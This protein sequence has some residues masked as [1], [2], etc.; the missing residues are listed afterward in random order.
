MKTY[1]D[2]KYSMQDTAYLYVGAKYTLGEILGNEDILYKFRKATAENLIKDS[3]KEDTLET[4]LYYLKPD[5][6]RM[7]VLKQM[8]AKVRVS[9][10][11]EFKR[12][13]KTKKEYVT[14]FMT[15]QELTALSFEEKESIGLV[16]QELKV[17][18]L[19][20]LTV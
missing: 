18:K 9:V 5:D 2:Y 4:M 3:D 14:E 19:A 7:Q 20:L 12:F 6:F 1:E 15:V 10:I 17:N 8:R 11:K 13:G 16:I